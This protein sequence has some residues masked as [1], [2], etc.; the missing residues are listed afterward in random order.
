MGAGDHVG[1]VAAGVGLGLEL[2]GVVGTVVDG[3]AAVNGADAFAAAA[4]GV[5]GVG[6]V[7][8][9]VV[10]GDR[11]AGT[12]HPTAKGVESDPVHVH[13]LNATILHLLGLDHE[14]L[15]YRSGGRDFRL[16][17]VYGDVVSE[18]FA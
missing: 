8:V 14:R 4:V 3:A 15:T 16:T 10:D 11:F 18:L 1:A 6:G 12:T 2:E 13:D 17:D 9:G 7:G 5:A